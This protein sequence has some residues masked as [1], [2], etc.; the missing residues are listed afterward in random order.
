VSLEVSLEISL[1]PTRRQWQEVGRETGG[2]AGGKSVWT[3]VCRQ[4]RSYEGEELWW[5]RAIW[6]RWATDLTFG[7]SLER[8]SANKAAGITS[9]NERVWD[10]RHVDMLMCAKILE[11][12]Q[13]LAGLGRVLLNLEC[14]KQEGPGQELRNWPPDFLTLRDGL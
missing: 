4:P 5:G 12:Q 11:Q 7:C 6:R 13:R 10:L 9:E 2:G 1:E 3:F 8:V 14:G